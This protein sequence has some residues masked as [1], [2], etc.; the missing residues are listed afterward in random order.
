[1][2]PNSLLEKM[3]KKAKASYI[4]ILSAPQTYKR[5]T[6]RS[7]YFFLKKLEATTKGLIQTL[8]KKKICARCNFKNKRPGHMEKEKRK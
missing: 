7:F 8:K 1:M 6:F 4:S 5:P 2:K 3:H